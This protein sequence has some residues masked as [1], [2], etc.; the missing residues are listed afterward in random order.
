MICALKTKELKRIQ[1][2][3]CG[4]SR[5][6]LVVKSKFTK[7]QNVKRGKIKDL[8][9]NKVNEKSGLDKKTRKYF[10]CGKQGH[11]KKDCYFW[12]KRQNQK[13]QKLPS[14]AGGA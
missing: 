9:G 13:S 7:N 5:E 12:K 6:G 14:W 8:K 10:H 1:E 3:N 11:L 2:E 4:S